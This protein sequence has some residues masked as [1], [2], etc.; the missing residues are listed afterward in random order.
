MYKY[1]YEVPSPLIRQ[2]HYAIG[3]GASGRIDR[4]S[5]RCCP[6][7]NAIRGI[8][9]F[10]RLSGLIVGR[11]CKLITIFLLCKKIQ[12]RVMLVA[13]DYVPI[14][15]IVQTICEMADITIDKKY[16]HPEWS[17]FN[18]KLKTTSVL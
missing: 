8:T 7:L 2:R 18:A 16:A 10:L 11:H 6:V 14:A 15:L 5:I 13:I 3:R 17:I 4:G 1:V 9:P 12:P